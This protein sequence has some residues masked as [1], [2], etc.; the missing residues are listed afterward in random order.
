MSPLM[1][2]QSRF[3][4][5]RD[6]DNGSVAFAIGVRAPSGEV[7]SKSSIFSSLCTDLD[8]MRAIWA[9]QDAVALRVDVAEEQHDSLFLSVLHTLSM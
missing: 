1:I 2:L 8:A 9:N 7:L 5:A 3:A 4:L 6:A